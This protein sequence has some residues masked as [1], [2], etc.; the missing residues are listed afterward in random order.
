M[1]M[2]L[3]DNAETR[4]ALIICGLS[5]LA[6]AGPLLDV[7]G[8]NPEVFVANRTTPTQIAAF[9]LLVAVLVPT[10]GILVVRGMS[11]IGETAGR[12]T[13]GVVI[14]LLTSAIGMVVAR[15]LTD[16][17]LLTV[18]IVVGVVALVVVVH[19][20]ARG[21]LVLTSLALPVVVVLFVVASPSSAL[22]WDAGDAGDL[23]GE[24]GLPAPVLFVQ[25][26]ELPLASLMTIQGEINEKLF[27][28]F[29]RL[30]SEGTWYRNALGDSIATTQAIPAVLTGRR[31]ERAATPSA[32]DHPEN[33]FTLL[34]A[35]Y[36]MQVIEWVAA[37]CPEDVCP[38]FAG[39]AA[40]RF[41]SLV[42]DAAV[43]YLHLSVPARAQ[44]SLPSID[45]SWRGFLGQGE[46][47]AGAE[48]AV[49]GLPVPGPRTR[50]DWVDWLQ[51]IANGVGRADR[52][53]LSYVHAPSPHVPW[54]TNPS[55]THYQRPE[56]YTE[57]EGVDGSGLW[58]A[59][60]DLGVLGFQR[61]LYQL[62][63][64]DVMLG[65]IF[66]EMDQAG[67]WE[68]SMV[69]V[70]SDHGTSFEAGQHRRWPYEE[71][72]A[73][74]YRIPLFIKYPGQ[75]VG[76]VVD[77]PAFGI[78][79]MPTVVDTLQVRTEWEFDGISLLDLEGVH[80][81]HDPIRWCCSGDPVSTDLEVL[82]AQV[83]RNHR[84]IPDQSSWL[85]VAGVGSDAGLI[86]VA[87]ETLEVM[88][89]EEVAWQ[90][91]LGSSLVEGSGEEGMVQTYVNGRISFPSRSVPDHLLVVING[92]IA[93][94]T[95]VVPDGPQ[96][97][98]FH[99][100]IAEELVAAGPNLIDLLVPG[101]DGTWLAGT[102]R[103]LALELVT[104][105]G[106]V[107]DIR[108]EGARRLQVDRIDLERGVWTI[109]GWSADIVEKVPPHTLYV[110]AADSL[111]AHGPPNLDNRNVVVWF[112]SDDLLRSGFRFEIP[113][114]AIPAGTAQLTVVA[115]FDEHAVADPAR[116]DP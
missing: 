82:D 28:N 112:A 35:D 78:D 49:D 40:A 116:L 14:T 74:L 98:T 17:L 88:A 93:G 113:A 15:Q 104:E 47:V 7:Y 8:R 51:M 6:V 50:A 66:T 85:G 38:D 59:N 60:Q 86:G 43:V 62:G 25:L 55:G 71:N 72:R 91:D 10:V 56:A 73:D 90:L 102:S 58:A 21:F 65:R 39:R 84:W 110:F 77:E 111:L 101:P 87:V 83:E 29:A 63:L 46:A 81:Q 26:D 107:L 16:N 75:T 2:R 108:S 76:E 31:V 92:T 54:M 34:A 80:R 95:L 106:R 19:R 57:V 22:I 105:D 23:S 109:V 9:A 69:I 67:T 33:L 1:A 45:N 70:L 20:W 94:M 3:L 30:A 24:V 4:R 97:G 36:E 96:G 52:P 100:M 53:V 68:E 61:H 79:V 115:E 114:S 18:L 99:G 64:L 44:G 37:M 89:S 12:I 27:P 11:T 5:T 32:V 41:G 42:A 48:V 103:D 13:Y